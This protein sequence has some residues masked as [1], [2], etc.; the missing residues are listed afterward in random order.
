MAFVSVFV[1]QLLF[2]MHKIKEINQHV[3]N[4]VVLVPH[5]FDLKDLK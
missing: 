5:I 3:L 4:N 1:S 2:F